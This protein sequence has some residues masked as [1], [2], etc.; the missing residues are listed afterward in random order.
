MNKSFLIFLAFFLSFQLSLEAQKVKIKKGIAYVDKKAFCK[1]EK[2]GN[3]IKKTFTISNLNDDELIFIKSL[4]VQL[5]YEVLF[6]DDDKKMTIQQTAFSN[7]SKAFVKKMYKSK[8]IKDGK[9]DASKLKKFILKY[10]DEVPVVATNPSVIVINNGNNGTQYEKISRDT[11]K[12]IFVYANRIEQDFKTIAT[13]TS[14]FNGSVFYLGSS[15]NIKVADVTFKNEGTT[16]KA[17]IKTTSDNK[18]RTLSV[19]FVN[20]NK[21]VANFLV[22]ND[23]L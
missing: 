4:D 20:R 16:S 13:V 3:L 21:E 14:N 15:N 11:S 23:Y 6:L 1:I 19:S 5:F 22:K 8:L 18:I 7:F 17:I 9:I 10:S 2:E 12:E